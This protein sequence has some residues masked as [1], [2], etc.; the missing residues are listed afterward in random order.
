MNN[1]IP[2]RV[3]DDISNFMTSFLFKGGVLVTSKGQEKMDILV[4][5]GKVEGMGEVEEMRGRTLRFAPCLVDCTGFFI[6]SNVTDGHVHFREPGGT[7]K[8]DFETGSRAA[9]AGGITTVLDMPNNQ[10]SIASR[11]VLAEK[12]KLISKKAYVN[13]GL[14]MGATFDP[15]TGHTN[16]DEFLASDA[17]ALKVYMGSSTGD[18]LVDQPSYLEEIFQKAG[19]ADRLVVV[20]AEDEA[21]MKE[22]LIRDGEVAYRLVKLALHLAKKYGTRMHIAHLSTARE[23]EEFAKF[24]NDRISCEVAPHHLFLTEVELAKQG[25]FAKMNPPLRTEADCKALIEGIQSGLV[26]MVATD[27][28]PHTIEEKKQPYS[29][30]PSGVPGEETML[31]LLLDA[32]HHGDLTLEQVARVVSEGPARVFR[33]K[34]GGSLKVGGAANFTGVD[35]T[36]EHTVENGGFG[37]RYTKCGWSVYAGRLLRG[38]PVLTVVNGEIVFQGE[39]VLEGKAGGKEIGKI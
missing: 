18:L 30:A 11:E 15:T 33:L 16:I 25:N 28:A 20:H 37:A 4:K 10:P 36:A 38:W 17:V 31:P 7:H 9:C 35:M 14:Y 32:V 13:Y 8:E 34:S 21:L 3:G 22:N 24:K 12:R 39:K 26:D 6:F 19:E 29:K 5:G 1:W 2:D 27:H 23:L